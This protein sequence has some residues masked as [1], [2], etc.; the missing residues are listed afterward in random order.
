M[1]IDLALTVAVELAR[2]LAGR[3]DEVTLV[4]VHLEMNAMRVLG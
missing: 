3:R 1:E 4:G 2:R